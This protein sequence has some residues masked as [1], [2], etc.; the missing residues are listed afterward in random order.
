VQAT[1]DAQNCS[2]QNHFCA[3][4]SPRDTFRRRLAE[5][6]KVQHAKAVI[7]NSALQ[8]TTISR[9]CHSV[10]RTNGSAMSA[11]NE[12]D[13][14]LIDRV[15]RALVLLAYFIQ[16]DGDAHVAMYEKFEAEL[17]ELKRREG[18]NERAL[19]LL[20]SYSRSGQVKAICSKNLSMSSKD[21][22]LPYLG[23]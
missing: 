8:S 16:I 9:C 10:F 21:G 13:M 1:I 11:T 7:G 12:R 22:P 14:L 19:R 18:T 4:W 6:R 23:L 20:S 2:E 15:E 17:H 3:G 5:Q